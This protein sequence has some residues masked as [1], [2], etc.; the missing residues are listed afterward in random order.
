MVALGDAARDLPI[1]GLIVSAVF[2]DDVVHQLG[3]FGIRIRIGQA[4]FFA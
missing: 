3:P 1:H 4:D 2:F